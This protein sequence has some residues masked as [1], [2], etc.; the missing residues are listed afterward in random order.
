M[1]RFEEWKPPKIEHNITTKYGWRVSYP[2]N[3][4]LGKYT[5]IGFGTYIMA[6]YGVI[7]EDDVEIG[8]HC[9]IYSHN[10]INEKVHVM[11]MSK[12]ITKGK[13]HLKKGGCIGAH[14]IILPGV[15]VAENKLIKAHSLLYEIQEVYKKNED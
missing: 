5:D 11:G 2:E 12:L 9:S 7:I 4:K 15:V 1:G 13:V 3:F 6:K 10:T 14:T 8:S